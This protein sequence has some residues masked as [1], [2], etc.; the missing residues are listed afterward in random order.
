MV[1]CGAVVVF[2]KL[3]VADN[4]FNRCRGLMGKP[5]LSEDTALLLER[6]NSVH[7]FWMCFPIDVIFLDRNGTVLSV[8]DHVPARR[9]VADR[10]AWQVL[11]CNAGQAEKQDV[12][13]GMRLTFRQSVGSVTTGRQ[14]PSVAVR[15]VIY[16]RTVFTQYKGLK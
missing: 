3:I 15:A 9:V 2:Q 8:S 5:Y 7:T 4:F 13:P 16:L 14:W 1:M 12:K 11:E 10:K 6:C